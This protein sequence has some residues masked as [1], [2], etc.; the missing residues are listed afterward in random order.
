MGWSDSVLVA[1]DALY[2]GGVLGY[3]TVVELEG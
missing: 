1:E 2:D 3:A